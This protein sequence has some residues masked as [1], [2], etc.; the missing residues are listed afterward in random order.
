MTIT[1]K[2]TK[3]VF[4]D[5]TQQEKGGYDTDMWTQV[6]DKCAKNITCLIITWTLVLVMEFAV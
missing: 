6:C 2:E 3:T 4:D 5:Y 1:D